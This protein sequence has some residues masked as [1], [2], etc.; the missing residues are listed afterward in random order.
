ML[1][2]GL[3]PGLVDLLRDAGRDR[4][5]GD[6]LG[7][8]LVAQG[9]ADVM[10]ETGVKPWDLAAPALIVTEAGGRFTRI[11]GSAGHDGPTALATNGRLHDEVVERLRAEEPG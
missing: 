10:L 8:L 6:T 1:R 5:F 4:G 11:D 3:G 7:Y 9:A 2:E